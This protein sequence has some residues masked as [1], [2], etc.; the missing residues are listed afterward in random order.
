ML[1]FQDKAG[2]SVTEYGRSH[3][4]IFYV[5]VFE[6]KS[7]VEENEIGQILDRYIQD[8]KI[9]VFDIPR[10]TKETVAKFQSEFRP[11]AEYFT[12]VYTNPG[13]APEPYMIRHVDEFLK[14]M[15]VLIG[16]DRY[17]TMVFSEEER[18]EGI[19]VCKV[20][21]YREAR[22]EARG[23]ADTLVS[24]VKK[25]LLREDNAAEEMGIT[26]EEF[27]ELMQKEKTA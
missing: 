14:L 12:N 9:H 21:D 4:N 2:V 1:L 20:L 19:E 11:V 22:G 17:E 25:G 26:V 8:Y 18:M 7:V 15:K 13:Y 10:L 3:D 24:L 23:R 27:L 5:L 16:D 6:G